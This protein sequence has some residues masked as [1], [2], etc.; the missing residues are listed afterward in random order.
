MLL[1]LAS[2]LACPIAKYILSIA[3]RYLCD[4]SNRPFTMSPEETCQK[5]APESEMMLSTSQG[6]WRWG[7]TGRRPLGKRAPNET[8]MLMVEKH[9]KI[10][11]C[12]SRNIAKSSFQVEKNQHTSVKT[13]GC[14]SNTPLSMF[15]KRTRGTQTH[16]I[17]D[18]EYYLP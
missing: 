6:G 10:E 5:N 8:R 16:G 3:G 1:D 15:S 18:G 12:I 13:M 11:K 2:H 7:L 4:N 9:I 14:A 17:L